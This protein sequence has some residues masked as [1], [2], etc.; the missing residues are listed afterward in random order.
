[1]FKTGDYVKCVASATRGLTLGKVY[2]IKSSDV[3]GYLVHVINDMGL[4]D[5]FNEI[6]F[7]HIDDNAMNRL[8][9]PEAFSE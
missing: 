2:R 6:R 7:S 8:L 3:R 5:F 1:M 4:N 9:Y